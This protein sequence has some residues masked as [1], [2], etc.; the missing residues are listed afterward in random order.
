MTPWPCTSPSRRSSWASPEVAKAAEAKEAAKERFEKIRRGESVSGGGLGKRT[1]LRALLHS[2]LTPSQIRHGELLASLT[3]AEFET[4]TYDS[5]VDAANRASEK[6]IDR[7]V[8]RNIRARQ[9]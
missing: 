5:A 9:P 8:R 3:R 1:D 6:E 4:L 7:E 2:L